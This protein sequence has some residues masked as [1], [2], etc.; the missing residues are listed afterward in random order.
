MTSNSNAGLPG[1][2]AHC[3]AQPCSPV[4]CWQ[5]EGSGPGCPGAAPTQSAIVWSGLWETNGSRF[6]INGKLFLSM[7]GLKCLYFPSWKT[8]L[9][10]FLGCRVFAFT[11]VFKHRGARLLRDLGSP[12][13][14][15][16]RSRRGPCAPPPGWGLRG[17]QDLCPG[18]CKPSASPLRVL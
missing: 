16:N 13:G 4:S 11:L 3:R 7:E 2:L 5:A 18:A 6:K 15:R 17:D 9:K 8:N 12:H 14:S 1:A 10:G